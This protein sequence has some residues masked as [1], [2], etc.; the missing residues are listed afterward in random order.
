MTVSAPED[1][2]TVFSLG[3]DCGSETT[4]FTSTCFMNICR[5]PGSTHSEGKRQP[6]PR[7]RSLRDF[8]Y[9]RDIPTLTKGNGSDGY[10]RVGGAVPLGVPESRGHTFLVHGYCLRPEL[11]MA[12][13]LS[14]SSCK[15][16]SDC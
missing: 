2:G 4:L 3:L 14:L 15:C 10:G 8:A 9:L 13:S 5:R 6:R 16:H 7:Q 12:Q 1:S 11:G